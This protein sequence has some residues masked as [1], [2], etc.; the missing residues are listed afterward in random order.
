MRFSCR[1]FLFITHMRLADERLCCCQF[2]ICRVSWEADF[3]SQLLFGEPCPCSGGPYVAPLPSAAAKLRFTESPRRPI[4][5]PNLKEA[6]GRYALK[7]LES[8]YT[9]QGEGVIVKILCQSLKI[10]LNWGLNIKIRVYI[11]VVKIFKFNKQSN[12]YERKWL[13]SGKFSQ[14]RW[15][16]CPARLSRHKKN[17]IAMASQQI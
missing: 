9:C 6:S 11:C 7:R 15:L 1:N 10:F 13:N 12:F 5:N 4:S 14:W 3:Q 8:T 2:A 17:E 16:C